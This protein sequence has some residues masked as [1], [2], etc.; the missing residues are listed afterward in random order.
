MPALSHRG[1]AA[2]RRGAA[3]GAKIQ[4]ARAK[5]TPASIVLLFPPLA[6]MRRTICTQ[7]L[8][9]H[10]QHVVDTMGC[11]PWRHA[12]VCTV[13]ISRDTVAVSNN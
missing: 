6:H 5:C 7:S 9:L 11:V 12:A 13:C 10:A 1:A 3:P 4:S 8:G 2:R